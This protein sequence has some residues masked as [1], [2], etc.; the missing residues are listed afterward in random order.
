MWFY[1][2]LMHQNDT[3]SMA[4]SEQ[5]YQGLYCLCTAVCPKPKD[6]CGQKSDIFALNY[7]KRLL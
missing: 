3:D 5:S 7:I 6:C 1:H 2:R 4:N